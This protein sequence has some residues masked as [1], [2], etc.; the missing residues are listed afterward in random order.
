MKKNRL[1]KIL[2][3]AVL[4]LIVILFGGIAYIIWFQPRIPVLDIKVNVTADRVARGNYLANHVLV[5]IDCHSTRDWA[6]FSGPVISGTEGKGGEKFDQSMG[7]PGIFVSANITPYHLSGWNDGE[8]YRA[9]TSGVGKGNRPF[10]PVMPYLY[11][12]MLDTEDIYSV[13]TYIRSLNPITYDP[14]ASNPDFP[15]NIILHMIP[16]PAHPSKSP[17]PSD[18]LNYGKYL[19]LA[20]G[21]I[22]CHTQADKRGKLNKGMSFAGG[23][24]FQMPSGLLRSAN[25]TSDKETGIG[26]Y[27]SSVFINRFKAYDPAMNPIATVKTGDFN[28][29]MPWSMYAGMTARD[30][31]SIFQYLHSLKPIHNPVVKF[32][33]LK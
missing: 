8:L 2:G 22:E 21:C 5:C 23:R 17:E 12:G 25:I 11:Y 13:M 28:S 18:S 30:L 31:S 14:E 1:W 24:E 32:I 10:F 6:K 4:G 7:F 3:F 29:I 33:P 9:I 16:A 26:S 19:V 20:G 27:T 15:M